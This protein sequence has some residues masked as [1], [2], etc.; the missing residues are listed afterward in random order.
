MRGMRDA[1]FT[2]A[3]R[4]QH[5]PRVQAENESQA[6]EQARRD[7]A[8]AGGDPGATEVEVVGSD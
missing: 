8:G 4:H 5:H 3:W 6:V 2:G 1:D 7:I